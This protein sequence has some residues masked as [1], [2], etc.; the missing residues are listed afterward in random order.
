MTRLRDWWRPAHAPGVQMAL[1]LAA[2]VLLLRPMGPWYVQAP[3]LFIGALAIVRP[4]TARVPGLWLAAALAIGA[5]LVVEWPLPD[6]HIYLTAYWC[7]AAALALHGQ[8]PEAHLATASRLL[9][10]L[11][12]TLAVLWKALLSPDYLD[13]RF[14]R[15]TLIEDPR[16]AS[17]SML[18]G[19]LTD[20]QLEENRAALAPLPAGAELLDPP[21]LR[22]PRRLRVLAA[23]L[24]WGGVGLEALLALVLWVP[25]RRARPWQHALLLIFCLVTYAVAPVAGFGWLLLIMGLCLCR[26]DQHAL[27]ATYVA[28][29]FVVLL[30]TEIPWATVLLHAWRTVAG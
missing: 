15:V 25:G 12:M 19:G 16:F 18:A 14:F 24:T 6:N 22:E 26:P 8:E 30:V 20:A 1:T 21:I 9:L 11:A 28:T 5:R 27:R 29:F 2:I 23:G 3:L 4:E 10:A 13:Q 17:V 7:L